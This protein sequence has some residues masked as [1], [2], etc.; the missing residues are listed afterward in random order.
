MTF[1]AGNAILGAALEVLKK[2]EKGERPAE[3][4]Y[5]YHPPKTS[6]FDPETG[7]CMPNFSYGY[8]AEAIEAEVNTQTGK[9]NLKRVTCANDVGK[10][11][12][13]L[14]VAGQIEGAI[15]QASGYTL[16]ENFIQQGGYVKTDSLSTYL[17]PTILDIPEAI[18]IKILEITDPNGPAGARG[19]GEMPYIPFAPAV[20][21]AVHDATRVWFNSFPL[22]DETILKGLGV[23]ANDKQ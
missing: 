15:V 5:T 4:T 16:L 6:P 22:T 13:P 23:L 7:V 11:I 1:M 19:M 17:I 12:N 8:V 20:T 21:A 3:S 10:A 2:W 18:D 14:Q 9:V